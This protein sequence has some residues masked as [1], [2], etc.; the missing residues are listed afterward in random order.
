[1][2]EIVIFDIEASCEDKKINPRYNMET[3][4]IGAVKV[5]DGVITDKFQTFIKPEYVNSLTPFCTELTGITYEDLKD[6]PSFNEGILDFYSFI[7]G[8]PIYSCGEFDRKFLTRELREKGTNYSHTIASEAIES[9]HKN[10]KKHYSTITKE[11][12]A[13][14]NKMALFL[15]VEVDGNAHR[16]LDDS[17]N[18]AKIYIKLEDMRKEKL[19]KVFNEKRIKRVLEK[20]NSNHNRNFALANKDSIEDKANLQKMDILTFFDQWR[21]VIITDHTELGLNYLNSKELS[22]IRNLAGY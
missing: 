18:L 4:E 21:D 16:A 22:S 5:K 6:A 11:K 14:M 7:Y 2:K 9:S 1:M 17:I 15:G 3:I 10:L 12:M 19:Q 13:G 20:I 8:L